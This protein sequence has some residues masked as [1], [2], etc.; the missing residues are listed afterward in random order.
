MPFSNVNASNKNTERPPALPELLDVHALTLENGS[1]FS[2][3]ERIAL[4][5]HGR[6][7]FHTQIHGGSAAPM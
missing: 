7:Y 5:S 2:G 1:G 6:V 3:H 4:K